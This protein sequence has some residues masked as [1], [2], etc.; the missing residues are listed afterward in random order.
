[1]THHPRLELKKKKSIIF[2][3]EKFEVLILANEQNAIPIGEKLSFETQ[4]LNR[5]TWS[6]DI[7]W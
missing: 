7:K 3:K 6:F 4:S 5:G 1:M 2:K